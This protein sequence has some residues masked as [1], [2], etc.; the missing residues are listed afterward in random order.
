MPLL[1]VAAVQKWWD[2]K[3]KKNTPGTWKYNLITAI[4]DS[5]ETQK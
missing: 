1:N 4:Q 3:T 5:S 2:T